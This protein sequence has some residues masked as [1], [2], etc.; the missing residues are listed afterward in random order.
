MFA[1][2]LLI[3]ESLLE[4]SVSRNRPTFH[5]IRDLSRTFETSLTASAYRTMG[6]TTFR[7]AIVGAQTESFG[8]SK[9]LT[10]SRHSLRCMSVFPKERT[11]TTA[12]KV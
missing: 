10:N 12:F 3:P 1:G 5:M 11:P 9:Q 8:G 4:D 6:L 7:A 2:E